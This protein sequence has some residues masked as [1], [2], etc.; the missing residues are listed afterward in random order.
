M[1]GAEEYVALLD[2][3]DQHTPACCA[4]E[5]FV[6]DDLSRDERAELS[7]ICHRCPV[8][9]PCA[10]YAAAGKPTAGHWPDLERRER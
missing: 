6:A 2:A 4:D 3:L 10:A 1:K 5:R 7:Q 8:R 9:K